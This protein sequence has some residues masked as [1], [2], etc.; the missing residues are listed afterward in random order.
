MEGD[1]DEGP[2]GE[3]RMGNLQFPLKD[4][5]VGKE[6]N[7]QVERAWAVCEAGCPVAPVLLF[8]AEK[9]VKQ[10]VRIE[11]GFEGNDGVHK[12]RLRGIAYRPG[13]VEGRPC[14]DAAQGL[15][16]LGRGG[17][18]GF[19]RAGVAWYITAHSDVR[20]LHTFRLSRRRLGRGPSVVVLIEA[21]ASERRVGK[22]RD[23]SEFADMARTNSSMFIL[24]VTGGRGACVL[25]KAVSIR[26]RT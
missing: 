25:W 12:A 19:R 16:P 9:P 20:R 4:V 3:S 6:Q 17:Q 14:C 13:G 21:L 24:G 11:I 10:R 7:V 1:E 8:D 26:L 18:R 23:F 15:E 2:L 22:L 5:D